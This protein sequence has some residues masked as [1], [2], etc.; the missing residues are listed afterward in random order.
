MGDKPVAG[1]FPAATAFLE[2]AAYDLRFGFDALSRQAVEKGVD[3]KA[4]HL[5]EAL[6]A[7]NGVVG[8]RLHEGIV[9]GHK[10]RMDETAQ[11]EGRGNGAVLEADV[12]VVLINDM[13]NDVVVG[14]VL[15]MAMGVP[16]GGAEVHLDVA[17]PFDAVDG[18]MGVEEIGACITVEVA[19]AVDGDGLAIGGEEVARHHLVLPDV[20]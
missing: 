5:G 13:E 9:V 8:R 4:R 20:M 6:G 2:E 17:R 10:G 19:D 3:N 18:Q 12:A 11:F 7:G 1:L 16:V 14:R 15:R